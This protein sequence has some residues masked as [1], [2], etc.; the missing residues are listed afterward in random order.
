MIKKL[1]EEKT[2]LIGLYKLTKDK[3][4]RKKLRQIDKM[5]RKELENE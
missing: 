5:I 3:T 4:V 1:R 2:E